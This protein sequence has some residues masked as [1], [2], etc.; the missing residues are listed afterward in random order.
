MKSVMSHSFSQVPQAKI[1][2][3]Q[4]NR[5]SGYKTTMDASVLVPIFVDEVLPGDTF[6]LRSSIFARMATPL[7]PVMDN[8]Y[9]DQHYFFVPNRLVW[10]NWKKF[11]GEQ[12]NPDDPTDFLVPTITSPVGGFLNQSVYDYLGIPTQVAGIEVNALPLRAINLIWNEW[13]RDENLQDSVVTNTDDGP[14]APTEYTLLKRG[15]RHDYFTSALPFPQKGPSVELPLGT[16]APVVGDGKTIGIQVGTTYSGLGSG[17]LAEGL[18]YRDAQYNTN[19]N[20][21]LSGGTSIT[22]GRS[23]GLTTESGKSGMIADLSTATVATINQL[24][25]ATQIQALYERDARGG[26]RYT[27]ILRAHFGVTSPDQRLQRPEFLG[28]SS[29]PIN[30]H[31]VPQTSSSVTGSPQGNL[32]AFATA[33]DQSA[34][35]VKS[36]TE[37]GWV[38]GFASV[39]A[40]LTYQQ[41]LNRMWSRQTRFDYYWPALSQLGEQAVLNK[42]IYAQGTSVD[43]EVFGYQERYAEYRYRPSTITGK[44]RSNDAQSLDTWH[45][46]QDFASLP[47]LNDEFIEEDVP[48]SRVLAVTDEPNFILDAY[49]NFICARPMPTY[50]IPTLGSRF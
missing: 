49:F 21:T 8:I 47:L 3:S 28:S 18:I 43:D 35:F 16:S 13:F 48:M 30:V 36:F 46:S 20:T 14:D 19:Q 34:G 29:T 44:F 41:G 27:E 10:D 38:I 9:M 17:G 15:K 33:S 45:L 12:R 40:D 32:S 7:H 11:N 26:T 4:F 5:S 31:T 22:S 1:P 37:H 42:E 24:R 6:N 23:V 50:S 25:E 2:R 39:R